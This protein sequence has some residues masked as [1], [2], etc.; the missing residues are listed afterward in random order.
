M[1]RQHER[2]ATSGNKIIV[3]APS[4]FQGFKRWLKGENRLTNIEVIDELV[5]RSITYMKKDS[6]IVNKNR[7]KIELNCA[8]KGL[9]N[10]QTTY[11]Q[12]SLVFAKIGILLD[13][14]NDAVNEN[15]N[16]GLFLCYNS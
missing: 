7:V 5:R 8:K 13:L 4:W 12:D 1:L 2:I 11:E 15:S 6:S 9:Q 14:I 3:E 10:L 16:N